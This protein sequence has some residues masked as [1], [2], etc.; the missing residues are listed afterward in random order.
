MKAIVKP[1]IGVAQPELW[2][3]QVPSTPAGW[4]KIKNKAVGLCGTDIHILADE[5]HNK[6][7]V[8][9]GHEIA[10]QVVECGKGVSAEL[11]GR[12]V[13][14][15][16]MLTCGKCRYCRIGKT[17]LCPERR[18]IGS[19]IDG[20]FAEYMIIPEDNLHFLPPGVDY[21]EG[22]L[23]EPLACCVRGVMEIGHLGAGERVL[24]IGPGTLGLLC[25]QLA[26]ISGA[27]VTVLGRPEDE[28]RLGL[29]G[30]LGADSVLTTE[31]LVDFNRSD[32][33]FETLVECSGSVDGLL[34]GTQLL[35]KNSK[36]IQVGL[37]GKTV[38]LLLDD[39]AMKEITLLGTFAH[40]WSTWDL[41]IRL[42][43]QGELQLRPLISHVFSLSDYQKAFDTF[44][45]RKGIKVLFAPEQ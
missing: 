21:Q 2:D 37:S 7:P 43:A 25:T 22:A 34:S 16:T 14:T 12:K 20:G 41:T 27:H 42:L 31:D 45:S 28:Q 19:V 32:G 13:T 39:F 10:G 44:R 1:N 26:K 15:R 36:I 33:E 5:Y 4:V 24:I 35:R 38:P 9:L 18:S 40:N 30:E 3:K 8:V 17:N 23:A 11:I 29:A 6:P